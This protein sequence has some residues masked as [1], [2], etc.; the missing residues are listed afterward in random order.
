MFSSSLTYRNLSAVGH[1]R[2]FEKQRR[3]Y[4][5]ES[6]E[7]PYTSSTA[8]NSIWGLGTSNSFAMF[9]GNGFR[10][11]ICGRYL[12]YKLREI[13]KNNP[14]YPLPGE[15]LA[16]FSHVIYLSGEV[17]NE[18][19]L[20]FFFAELENEDMHMLGITKQVV[21]HLEVIDVKHAPLKTVGHV[22]IIKSNIYD[23]LVTYGDQ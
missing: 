1:S 23:P 7:H 16:S 9:F 12:L 20:P 3:I 6:E 2:I 10:H 13:V 11:A 4:K 17:R 18:K 15:D 22:T 5:T 19:E 14:V 8:N 21:L